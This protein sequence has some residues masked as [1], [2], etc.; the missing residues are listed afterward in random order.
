[1]EPKGGQLKGGDWIRYSVQCS[2]AAKVRGGGSAGRAGKAPPS[3]FVCSS[4][5]DSNS[6]STTK[7]FLAFR[8]TESFSTQ[9]GSINGDVSAG[10]T[11]FPPLPLRPGTT[12][13][14]AS[15]STCL[16]QLEANVPTRKSLF[17]SLQLRL[18]PT[19]YLF[20][21]SLHI[22]PLHL[23]ST[24]HTSITKRSVQIGFYRS[25]GRPIVKVFLG[26]VVTYQVVYILWTKLEMDEVKRERIGT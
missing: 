4:S 6:S 22:T 16:E 5:L 1:M 8:P 14:W 2:E 3:S 10:S 17:Q 11:T 23:P 25:F 19:R 12:G 7:Y 13:Q 15:E 24:S 20:L 18:C 9:T 21:T 26:A